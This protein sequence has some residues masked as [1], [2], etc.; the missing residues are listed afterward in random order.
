MGCDDYI[1]D[2]LVEGDSAFCQ[3]RK[4]SVFRGLTKMHCHPQR[5]LY[6]FYYTEQ[7]VKKN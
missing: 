1:N 4:H 5:G 2:D 3:P 7:T 6:L